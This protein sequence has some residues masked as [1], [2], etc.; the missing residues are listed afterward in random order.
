MKKIYLPKLDYIEIDNYS[1]YINQPK[2]KFTFLDGIS[3]IVG[4]NGIGKTTFVNI[5]IYCLV[6]HKKVYN[7]KPKKNSKKKEVEYE[8]ID[9]FSSRMSGKFDSDKNAQA[10]AYVYF[11]INNFQI[12]IGRS[13]YENK[14]TSLNINGR[15]SSNSDEENYQQLIT[16]ISGINT[17]RDFE[18]IIRTFLFFDE[19]RM[20]IAWETDTQ[21]EILR[22]LLFDE[23]Y[24]IKFKELEEEVT[25]LDSK[26]RHASEN[27]RMAKIAYKSL[28]DDKNKLVKDVTKGHEKTDIAKLFEKK[29]FLDEEKLKI[30]NEM[31]SIIRK[32]NE[33]D[34]ELNNLIGEKENISFKI[35]KI[36]EEISKLETKLYTSVYDSL[37]DYYYTLEHSIGNDGKCLI[38]GSK[39][40]EI[41]I[42]SL[43]KINNGQCLVCSSKIKPN[44]EIDPQSI[45]E[46]NSLNTKK[47]EVINL[48]QNKNAEIIRMKRLIENNNL[49]INKLNKALDDKKREIIYIELLISGNNIEN[50]TDT[51]TE[52]L[53][54]KQ[55]TIAK[56]EEEINNAYTLRD[57][58]KK[59]LLEYNAKFKKTINNLNIN[60]SEY[61]N[62]YASTFIGLECELTVDEK[63]INK[64]PHIVYLPKIDGVIRKNIWAVSESQRFFLDQAFR[65]AIIDYLQNTINGFSTYFITET[66]E[67]S[68]DIAYE[69]QVAK[70][71]MQFSESC[72]NIIFTS[73][74]NSSSFLREIFEKIN[75]NER[76]SRIL[77]LLDKG[78]MTTVQSVN[79]DKLNAKLLELLGSGY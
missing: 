8:D 43:S 77:N 26:G 12:K 54:S 67:G 34:S 10:V 51:Y 1:L 65:M 63:E 61:F 75:K 28:I 50:Q 59:E 68:L 70:M 6:G 52:I 4:V 71:F 31:E 78:K 14:I 11:S 39:S 13:L 58:K 62:K 3:A 18:K 2:F 72:N 73:N 21:D 19:S 38:C 30:Q 46:I 37:P 79:I 15:E 55:G 25:T 5:I 36:E 27:R 9:F 74:L 41:K 53:K 60:L 35:E 23:K 49:E 7:D 44:E 20:N 32:I 76:K 66:P 22:I 29:N 64:I 16:D 40:K 69:V 56:L 57:I 45:I 33:Q 48:L 17:F 24:F 42:S 47:V